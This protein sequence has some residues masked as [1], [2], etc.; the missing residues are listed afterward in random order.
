[1]A[2]SERIILP[3]SDIPKP[4]SIRFGSQKKNMVWIPIFDGQTPILVAPSSSG[5]SLDRG[6]QGPGQPRKTGW[7]WMKTRW[8]VIIQKDGVE[9]KNSDVTHDRFVVFPLNHEGST[10]KN[11]RAYLLTYLP[12]YLLLYLLSLLPTTHPPTTDLRTHQ[13]THPLSTPT[14]PA[15]FR[16]AQAITSRSLARWL[17]FQH[18][19]RFCME[20]S[21]CCTRLGIL[22]LP[23]DPPATRK[24]AVLKIQN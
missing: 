10:M 7:F 21:C 2:T 12:T 9:I 8:D 22:E 20:L 5:I 24:I 15:W 4:K 3:F 1:M 6:R 14:L 13:P 16:H 18:S 11:K 17:D 19:P 23:T